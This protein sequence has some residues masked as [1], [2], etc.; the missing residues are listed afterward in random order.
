M[1]DMM[2]TGDGM[3]DSSLIKAVERQSLSD[4]VFEQLRDRI[5]TGDFKP[6][7]ALPSERSLCD[8]L[9]VNRGAVREALKRLEQSRLVTIRQGEATK[10]RDYRF[11]AGPELLP[12]L[13]AAQ[14]GQIDVGVAR[15]VMELRG[16]IA[17]DAA[18]LA[19]ERVPADLR[20]EVEPLLEAMEKAAG[21]LPKLQDLAAHL[22]EQLVH[23]SDNVAYILLYNS[24]RQ[25]YDQIRG[26]L[27]G[28]LQPE[29]EDLEGYRAIVSAILEGDAPGARSAAHALI[30]KGTQATLMALELLE[31]MET[32]ASS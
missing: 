26:E 8:L 18:R 12:A 22:W 13:L 24:M 14:E 11:S 29:L 15:S 32:E 10:V 23:A 21:D 30:D 20:A 3:K 17:P 1:M 2:Q 19:A 25:V 31:R 4:A 9:Q 16:L 6:G 28:I 5:L 27:L 7:E